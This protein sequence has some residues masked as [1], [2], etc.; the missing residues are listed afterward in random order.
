MGTAWGRHEKLKICLAA[1]N[2]TEDY[3]GLI[4]MK[5]DSILFLPQ[6]LMKGMGQ[7]MARQKIFKS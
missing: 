7:S 1:V 2:A 3:D 5:G 4:L 6:V